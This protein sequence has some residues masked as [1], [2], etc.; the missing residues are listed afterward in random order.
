MLPCSCF[1][2]SPFS[3]WTDT[4]TNDWVA[5]EEF[6]F[7]EILHDANVICGESLFFVGGV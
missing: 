7:N 1:L 4:Q 3:Q 2:R 6:N 5:R